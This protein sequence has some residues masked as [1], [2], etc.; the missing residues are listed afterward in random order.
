MTRALEVSHALAALRDVAGV[1]G[2]FVL[3]HDGQLL[4]KD[5]PAVFHDQLF[6]EVG[7]RLSRFMDTFAAEGDEIS[8]AVFRFEEHRLQ[9]TRFQHG[10]LAVICEN[11]VNGSALRM[12]LTLTTRRI[13]PEINALLT[14]AP[15]APSIAPSP[16]QPS[17][18][19]AAASAP[20]SPPIAG[21]PGVPRVYRG[22]IIS[23]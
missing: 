7:A 3:A 1:H 21:S 20:S 22:R 2:S 11:D 5:L 19:P 23:S 14:S 6:V 8:S 12:A 13:S 17:A 16:A 9:L 4:A 10:L 15:V 18:P